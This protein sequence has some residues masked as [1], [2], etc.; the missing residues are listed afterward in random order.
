MPPEDF[1]ILI[2]GT[3]EYVTLYGKGDFVCMIKDFE[4]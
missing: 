1:H 3:C 2:P 4:T